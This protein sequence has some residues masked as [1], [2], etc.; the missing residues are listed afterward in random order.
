MIVVGAT[1]DLE[2]VWNIADT[3]NGLMALP[4]LIALAS[5]LGVVVNVPRSI[6]PRENLWK[7]RNNKNHGTEGVPWDSLILE[8]KDCTEEKGKINLLQ[9]YRLR[10]QRGYI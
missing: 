5:C 2:L 7:N 4:N 6:L 9:I 10:N 3:L 8:K 1:V